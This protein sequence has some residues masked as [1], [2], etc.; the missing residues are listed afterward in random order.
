MPYNMRTLPLCVIACFAS[1][2]LTMLALC[3]LV[4]FFFTC[5]HLCMF[6]YMFMNVSLCVCFCH[7]AQ[8]LLTILSRF[9]P[10]FCIR[11]PKSL[12]ELCLMARVSSILQ[13]NGTTG[14]NPNP[15]LSFQDTLFCLIT[16]SLAPLCAFLCLFAPLCT[17]FVSSFS[18]C[19]TAIFVFFCCYMYTFG[20]RVQLP[21]CKLKRANASKKTQAQR[22]QCLVDRRFNLLEWFSLS[23]SLSFSLRAMFQGSHPCIQLYAAFLGYI[24]VCFIFPILCQAIPFGCRHVCVIFTCT[25]LGP[26]SLGMIISTL[27]FLYLTRPYPWNIG[28]VWFIFLLYRLALCMMYVYILVSCY[29]WL[30]TLYDGLSQLGEQPSH[31]QSALDLMVQVCTQGDCC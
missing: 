16:R 29:R 27:Y 3:H 20:V 8:F 4:C 26:C 18:F 5:L 22:G 9:T 28:N 11:G 25:L 21:R 24:N 12:Q 1:F 19:L 23:L 13:Y 17:F 15:H 2:V 10:I 6:F 30:C 14:T 31:N 7:Q